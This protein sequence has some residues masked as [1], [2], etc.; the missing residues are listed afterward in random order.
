VNL[1]AGNSARAI[2]FLTACILTATCAVRFD[3]AADEKKPP[4][5]RSDWPVERVIVIGER[6]NLRTSLIGNTFKGT[7]GFADGSAPPDVTTREEY[8]WQVYYAPDGTLEARFQR[9]GTAKPHAPVEV[10]TYQVQGTWAIDADGQLCQ[11]IPRVGSG[12]TVC[13]DVERA[14]RRFALYYESCGALTRCYAGRLGPEGEIL[15]GRI[16][17][18]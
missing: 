18:D 15:P 11:A 13:Y 14:G 16:F 17:A 12:A 7:E 8:S 9:W 1:I 3:A 6:F 2:L 5:S 4:Q 10:R